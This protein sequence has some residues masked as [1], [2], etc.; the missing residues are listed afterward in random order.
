MKS[1][2]L[3]QL[4]RESLMEVPYNS[5]SHLF[6]YFGG[7]SPDHRF[8]CACAWQA[9]ELGERMATAGCETIYYLRDH[10]HVTVIAESEG[11]QFLLDPYLLQAE[12]LNLSTLENAKRTASVPCFPIY[13]KLADGSTRAFLRAS[14]AKGGR[15]VKLT[16]HAYDP[17]RRQ[18]RTTHRFALDLTQRWHSPPPVEDLRPL[19]FDGEQNTLSIR[20]LLRQNH[21]LSQLL[22]PI[23]LYHGESEIEMERLVMLDN[24][25][26]LIPFANGRRFR[27]ELSRMSRSVGCSEDELVSFL[28]EGVRLYELHAPRHILYKPLHPSLSNYV[29]CGRNRVS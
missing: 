11:T 28:L 25:G 1:E 18:L 6:I 20:V 17:H 26:G 29:R 3:G 8:G 7:K 10:R 9:L 14:F 27:G 4:L 19:F 12:P 22:Y 23:A 5:V 15:L 13:T 2:R 24:D 21:R 16:R